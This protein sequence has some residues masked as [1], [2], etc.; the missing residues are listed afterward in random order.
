MDAQTKPLNICIVSRK[1]IYRNTRVVRQAGALSDAGHNVTV[2]CFAKPHE[3]L[4]ASVPRVRFIEVPPA[5][6]NA[7]SLRRIRPHLDMDVLAAVPPMCGSLDLL[8]GFLFWRAKRAEQRGCALG[9]FGSN[10]ETPMRATIGSKVSRLRRYN[11]RGRSLRELRRL[12]R[13]LKT[14]IYDVVQQ[15]PGGPIAW[16]SYRWVKRNVVS[17]ALPLAS[18]AEAAG[19]ESAGHPWKPWISLLW[20]GAEEIKSGV[21]QIA[22]RPIR[23]RQTSQKQFMRRALSRTAEESRAADTQ[24]VATDSSIMLSKFLDRLALKVLERK[25]R[26]ELA[27]ARRRLHDAVAQ[28]PRARLD[29]VIE[30]FTGLDHFTYRIVLGLIEDNIVVDV[31]FGVL[32][33]EKMGDVQFDCV[34]SHDY[35]SLLPA[36]VIRRHKGGELVYDAVEISEHRAVGEEHMDV[37]RAIKD[38][39]YRR[40]EAAIFLK[41]GKLLTVGEK[42]SEWYA[43]TYE[44]N[45]PRVLRNCR[46]YSPP[47]DDQ[48]LRN[49]CGIG[50]DVPLLL[51]FGGGYPKQG[52]SFAIEILAKMHEDVHLAMLTEFMPAWKWYEEELHALVEAKGLQDRV[53]FLP[54]Q[55]PNE[56]LRYAS[57]ASVGLIPRPK[58]DVLNVEYSLPNK[59]FEMIMSRTPIAATNLPNIQEII[60]QYDIGCTLI[61]GDPEVSAAALHALLD[62]VAKGELAPRLEAAARDLCWEKE[63]QRLVAFYAE[64]SG[65]AGTTRTRVRGA[66]RP[67]Q[68]SETD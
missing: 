49:D 36:E 31:G 30:S 9:S 40:I 44:I 35:T 67:N 14:K 18:E 26:K 1:N 45:P 59:L 34:Q 64:L 56:L 29:T 7:L 46:H 52:M 13:E 12:K 60:R 4:L 50:P 23:G 8:E 27:A 19:P 24:D 2:V 47:V 41:S 65:C 68:L 48:R 38:E 55:P 10:T 28:H 57:S 6:V 53:H 22:Q 63:S 25:R 16:E 51:W 42:L 37:D 21:Y 20:Q 58:S 66:H 32:A 33:L 39:I 62:E 3:E 15:V 17:S 61:D 5:Q 54:L 11:A 43:E